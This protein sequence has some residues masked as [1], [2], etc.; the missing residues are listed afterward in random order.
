MARSVEAAYQNKANCPSPTLQLPHPGHG[1]LIPYDY[2][3]SSDPMS[4]K[5]TTTGFACRIRRH[6]Y[7]GQTK[8][9]YVFKAAS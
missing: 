2:D 1:T 4:Q 9:F 7:Q 6:V 5:N 8:P 3:F